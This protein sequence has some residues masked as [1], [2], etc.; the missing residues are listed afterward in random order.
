MITQTIAHVQAVVS[1]GRRF[2][3]AALGRFLPVAKQ[4]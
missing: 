3:M 4:E 1:E 2:G